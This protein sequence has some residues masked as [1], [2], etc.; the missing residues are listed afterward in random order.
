V[1]RQEALARAREI[2]EKSGIEDAS[3]EGEI[4]LRHVLEVS[5]TQLYS[6]L[7]HELNP[8]QEKSLSRLLELRRLGEPSAYITGH[9]EF[10]GL[11]FIVNPS[12]L[13]PRPESELLVEMS[14]NLAQGKTI[15]KIADIGTGCGAIAVSLAVHLPKV[16][17][18]ATDISPGALE[19]AHFNCQ[20][21]GVAERVA[22]IAG[23]LLEPLEEPVDM[24]VANLPYV[25]ER[26]LIKNASLSFEPAVAL[27]GG[28]EGLDRIKSLC[29]QAGGKINKGG[30]LILEIGE[31]QAK[32][33]MAILRK[34][35]PEA[36]I[37][38][39]K[40]LA[41]IKRAVSLCLTQE[42]RAT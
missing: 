24:I 27:N 35:F 23:N 15:T 34:A 1:N 42:A 12:V 36:T 28:K 19:V 18:Y 6:A 40:D 8:E 9:R 10:Y 25:R 29:R 16:T 31:G 14:I 26:D 5:R 4:L 22:L 17:V 37:E 2:L 21:H 20:R 39:H 33:V 30:Y 13:I 41:G 3:L 11:D 38:I 7:D 32:A